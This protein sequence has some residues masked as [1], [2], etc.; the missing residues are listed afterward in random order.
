MFIIIGG[1]G[2]EYGP[3]TADQVRAWING[4]RA[5]LET[6]AK[7]AGANE[8]RR[9]GDFPE[10]GA[11]AEPPTIAAAAMDQTGAEVRPVAESAGVGARTGAAVPAAS[12]IA[13]R[14]PVRTAPWGRRVRARKKASSAST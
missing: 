4:G 10:F 11:P 6:R 12:P 8:W 1:D 5:N 2:R 7:Q 14:G 13:P 3:V 9:L